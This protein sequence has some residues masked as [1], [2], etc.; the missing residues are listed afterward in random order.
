MRGR[1]GRS[2]YLAGIP[3]ILLACSSSS[4]SP[5][6]AVDAAATSDATGV[7]GP[8]DA[9]SAMPEATTETDASTMTGPM[10]LPGPTGIGDSCN[11][12]SDCPMGASCDLVC[13][14]PCTT[15]ADCAGSHGGGQNAQ[16][17]QNRCV[18]TLD[19]VSNTVSL[20]CA[21]GCNTQNDCNPLGL[22]CEPAPDGDAGTAVNICEQV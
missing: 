10:L 4:T 2:L 14:A 6:G 8:T 9:S 19:P 20:T 3:A 11:F 1:C 5:A 16:G 21:P 15:D 22:V 18:Q 17:V 13:V 12:D 7:T